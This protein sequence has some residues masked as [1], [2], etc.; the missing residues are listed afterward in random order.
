M[1]KDASQLLQEDPEACFR[2]HVVDYRWDDFKPRLTVRE[3]ASE[4]VSELSLEEWKWFVSE[5]KRCPGP[6]RGGYPRCPEGTDLKRFSRCRSCDSLPV[7]E[8]V[9]EPRC[10]GSSCRDVHC[11]EPHSVYISFFGTAPKVGMT[12]SHRVRSRGIEQ[13]ADAIM[14]V[15]SC[16]NR[17]EAREEEKRLSAA[18]GV[19]QTVNARD[20]ARSLLRPVPYDDIMAKAEAMLRDNDLEGHGLV[21]LDGY[22]MP[23]LERAPIP[24]P[25]PGK[26]AGP[27]LGVKGRF[28]VYRDQTG[29]PKMMDLSDLVARY[30][31]TTPSRC[32]QTTLF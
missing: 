4:A 3:N 17:L 6:R 10:D 18:M 26:H 1:F 2:W 22:P 21:I 8:C 23:V 29:Q 30:L 5:V 20:F 24:V 11:A 7:Q 9:F 13:G 31:G 14:P 16:R 25:S 15:L 32:G 12:R 27:V 19:R 28:L